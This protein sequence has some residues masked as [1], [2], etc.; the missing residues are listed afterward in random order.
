MS[1]GYMVWGGGGGCGRGSH[2]IEVGEG[3]EV[4]I[5]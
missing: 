3:K 2:R 4:I 1:E 5:G